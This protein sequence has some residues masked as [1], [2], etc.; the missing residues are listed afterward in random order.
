[1]GAIAYR[2]RL[3]GGHRRLSSPDGDC[4]VGFI[5]LLTMLDNWTE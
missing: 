5:D 1:L 4:T 2:W 3:P